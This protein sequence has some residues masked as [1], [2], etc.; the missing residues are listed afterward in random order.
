MKTKF[1]FCI[2]RVNY[3]GSH[4][5]VL[6]V[7]DCLSRQAVAVKVALVFDLGWPVCHTFGLRNVA[8]LG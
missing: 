6:Q 3:Y 5:L 1:L 7:A 4:N 8:T 2:D